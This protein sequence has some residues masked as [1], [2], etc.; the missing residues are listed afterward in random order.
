VSSILS[1]SRSSGADVTAVLQGQRIAGS[2]CGAG[3]RIN[4]GR[5]YS[6]LGMGLERFIVTFETFGG[7]DFGGRQFVY[8]VVV[9]YGRDKAVALAA[10]HH[11]A[12]HPD[13]EIFTVN[14]IERGHPGLNPD[15]TPTINGDELVDRYE[16]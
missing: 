5:S 15:D 1:G 11:Y 7:E 14:V 6:C 4:R 12:I 2:P 3:S 8:S 10:H 13:A 9:Y 16:W